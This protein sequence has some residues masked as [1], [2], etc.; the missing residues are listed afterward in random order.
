MQLRW[1][2]KQQRHLCLHRL[3]QF[4][5]RQPHAYSLMLAA[6]SV[7]WNNS[8][9]NCFQLGEL[10]LHSECNSGLTQASEPG[11][12]RPCQGPIQHG[13]NKKVNPAEPAFAVLL[14]G[15]LVI[16]LIILFSQYLRQW[17]AQPCPPP[18]SYLYQGMH[19]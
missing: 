11:D 5:Q 19:M 4:L 17:C 3:E 6:Q 10:A 12:A 16:V 2:M 15:L 14:T 8:L 1:Q 9:G 13:V 7:G 18:P